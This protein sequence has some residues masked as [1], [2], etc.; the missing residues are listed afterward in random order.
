VTTN[1]I[2][3]SQIEHGPLVLSHIMP[4]MQTV[5]LGFFIDLGSRDE[6]PEQAGIAHAL[7]HMLFKGTGKH[8][9]HALSRML[10]R[11]GGSANAFTSR[12]RTC[13]HMHVLYEDWQKALDILGEMLL[14]AAI[15]DEE[16]LREREVIFAEMAMVEDTPE[17]WVLDQHM[18][19]LFPDHSLGRL[20]LGT[21]QS[22]LGLTRQDLVGYLEGHYRP[23]RL[24]IC[25][26]GRLE[27]EALVERVSAMHWPGGLAKTD[28][29]PATM[30]DGVQLLPRQSEQAQIVFSYPGITAASDERPVGWLANQILGGSM[31]SRLFREVREKRGLAYHI[32]SHLSSLS[33]TG[34]WTITGGTEPQRLSE[35][36]EVI[37]ATVHDV[38]EHGVKAGEFSLAQ[39]MTE[40]Q[41]RMGMDSVEGNMLR[42]G[43]RFDEPEVRHQSYWLE[44]VRRVEYGA[45]QQ[46]VA[47]RLSVSPLLTISGPQENLSEIASI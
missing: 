42:L 14:D 9:V 17:E 39:S 31:S 15:P 2:R 45:L 26:A 23:P 5:A 12:E 10:D 30:A 19:A 37:Q 21:Q 22:L 1:I 38:I 3:E 25:A 36:V 24:L 46:W 47:E 34:T 33:D 20:T 13:F 7:E 28:R 16:W 6:R 29:Q 44:Q 32:G 11:L 4:E 27:H 18:Q 41:L 43:A 8:D 40:V 35:C